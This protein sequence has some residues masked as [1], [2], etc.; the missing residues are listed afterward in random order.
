[1]MRKVCP[2]CPPASGVNRTASCAKRRAA[3]TVWERSLSKLAFDNGPWAIAW[4]RPA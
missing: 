1:M 4:S 2:S 3:V